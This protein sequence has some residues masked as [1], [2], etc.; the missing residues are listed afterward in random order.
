MDFVI[1]LSFRLSFLL[2][3]LLWFRL[4]FFAIKVIVFAV[5]FSCALLHSFLTF[6]VTFVA[7]T[8]AMLQLLNNDQNCILSHKKLFAEKFVIWLSFAL[9]HT[10]YAYAPCLSPYV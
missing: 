10:R 7:Q 3:M 9:K 4:S 2:L 8:K 1:Y 5:C 6:C